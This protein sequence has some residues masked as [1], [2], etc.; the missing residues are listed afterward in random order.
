VQRL[1]ID[2]AASRREIERYARGMKTLVVALGFLA[3]VGCGGGKKTKT[4]GDLQNEYGAKLKPRMEAL[5][6]AGKVADQNRGTLGAAG[7]P[8]AGIDVDYNEDDHAGNT[9]IAQFD[10]LASLTEDAKPAFRFSDLSNDEVR[11][12]KSWTGAKVGLQSGDWSV[13]EPALQHVVGAKYV[14]VVFPNLIA[15]PSMGI[16]GTSFTAGQASATVVLVEIDGAKPLGGFEVKATNSG[17][18][19]TKKSSGLGAG[20]QKQRKIEADLA[21]QLGKEIADGIRKRWKGA[22]APYNWGLGW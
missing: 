8:P 12:A 19:M 11:T 10:D 17:E 18:I 13:F 16:G 2:R 15:P 7:D 3:V 4:N 21:A 1:I 14:L 20:E 6:A 5:I 9:V 22:K